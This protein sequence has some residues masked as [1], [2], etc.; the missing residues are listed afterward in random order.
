MSTP[1]TDRYWQ[2]QQSIVEDYGEMIKALKAPALHKALQGICANPDVH[3]R[4]KDQCRAMYNTWLDA[5][6]HDE[7]AD[8]P[9]SEEDDPNIQYQE[10]V[11]QKERDEAAR[12]EQHYAPSEGFR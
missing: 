5:Q 12:A 9:M 4:T 8:V 1:E 10:Y 2:D 3:E 7:W 11:L 6:N